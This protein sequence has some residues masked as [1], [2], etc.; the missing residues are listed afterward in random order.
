MIIARGM[1]AICGS[2][3]RRMTSTNWHCPLFRSFGRRLM[4]SR[5]P[6]RPTLAV[7]NAQDF[8][9]PANEIY[10]KPQSRDRKKTYN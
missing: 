10:S 3:G 7:M 6:A 4:T 2:G 5:R 8:T 9:A 1:A